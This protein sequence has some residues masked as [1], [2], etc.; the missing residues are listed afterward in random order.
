MS[1]PIIHTVAT[2]SKIACVFLHYFFWFIYTINVRVSQ[3]FSHHSELD[4]TQNFEEPHERR[5]P[6]LRSRMQILPSRI[7]RYQYPPCPSLLANEVVVV[8]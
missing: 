5:S 6:I 7:D 2:I 4:V 3:R 1:G 8:G